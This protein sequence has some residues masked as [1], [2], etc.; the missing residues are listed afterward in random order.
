MSQ[1]RTFHHLEHHRYGDDQEEGN[2]TANSSTHSRVQTL[3]VLSDD[4][5]G[6]ETVVVDT[7]VR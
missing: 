5:S 2:L 4:V 1:P 7:N 6:V 3:E